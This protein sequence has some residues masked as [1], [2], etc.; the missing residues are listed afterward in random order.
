MSREQHYGFKMG[1]GILL[2]RYALAFQSIF[3]VYLPFM[4]T[5]N[6]MK[7]SS[8]NHH[9]SIALNQTRKSQK[10][11]HQSLREF[12]RSTSLLIAGIGL[13]FSASVMQP[14][15]A[16]DQRDAMSLLVPDRVFDGV[17][18]HSDWV[19]LVKGNKIEAVGP[20][21][22][23]LPEST[24]VIELKGM[25]VMPGLIEGHSH[26]FLHPYNET[27]WDDQV[28]KETRTERTLRA[29]NHAK[30]TLMAGFTTVR[31]LGTEGAGFDDFGLKRAIEKGVILGP[32]M[33]IASRA[34]VAKG[35][36]GPKSQNPDLDL[37]QGAA[38]VSGLEQISQEVRTQIG[39]GADVI[40]V[41][42]DYRAGRDGE[43]VPLFSVEEMAVMAKIANSSHRQL[44]AHAATPEGMRRAVDAGVSTIEHGDGGS[45]EV[46]RYMKEKG[47]AFC[48]TLAAGDAIEQYRGW[49]KS[50][51]PEPARI[52]AKRQSFAAALKVGVRICMGGDVGVYA[53]GDNVREMELMVDYGMPVI[54]VLRAATSGNA[55]IFGYGD[56]IGRVAPGMLA[57]LIAVEA[58]PTRD[59]RSLR[60]VK[61]V[62]KDGTVVKHKE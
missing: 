37:P 46:F 45:E 9:V 62:M 40:K 30:A 2:G 44:V 31:D 48:P 5:K 21:R 3:S 49:K 32:R 39:K 53:H 36:Y 15:Q 51:M 52:M 38:E 20:Q 1:S 8:L 23:K 29:G 17:N 19:V 56:K 43:A 58:D 10:L 54:D 18:M 34:L 26:L 57:D 12:A 35:A 25:T 24:K 61:W 28:L 42:A 16:Q 55:S 27:S 47:V 14:A 13:A 11:C 22:M 6:K 7:K 41:Y 59:L 4:T 60:Q 33:I 50:S